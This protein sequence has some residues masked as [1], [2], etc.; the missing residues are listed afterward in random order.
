MLLIIGIKF[1]KCYL[2]QFYICYFFATL[3][4][5]NIYWGMS[6]LFETWEMDKS[7]AVIDFSMP[8]WQ[9]IVPVYLY[10]Y[11]L[12]RGI[13]A[14][15]PRKMKFAPIKFQKIEININFSWKKILYMERKHM[16]QLPKLMRQNFRSNQIDTT[17][18]RH[19]TWDY[20]LVL[21][22]LLQT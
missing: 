4:T 17:F 1:Y 21:R 3:L 22:E 18:T 10:A 20:L 6:V 14:P 16:V 15:K 12:K 7:P 5:S 8:T 11:Q 2:L 19:G 13:L 9:K